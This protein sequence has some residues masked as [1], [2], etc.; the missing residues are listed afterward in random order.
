MSLDL[1][2]LCTNTKIY[3]MVERNHLE[4]LNIVLPF[5]KTFVGGGKCEDRDYPTMWVHRMI[6]KLELRLTLKHCREIVSMISW[7]VLERRLR[8][9]RR[10][11]R[12][13]LNYC[14]RQGC[15]L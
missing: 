1:N 3:R 15:K 2:G 10:C 14:V 12:E 6:C 9:S 13:R 11:G 7:E 4:A 5:V 8:S